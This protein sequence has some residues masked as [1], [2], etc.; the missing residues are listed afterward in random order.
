MTSN[1][2]WDKAAIGSK[3]ISGQ[4]DMSN[5]TVKQQCQNIP[6]VGLIPPTCPILRYKVTL[7]VGRIHLA[8]EIP[9]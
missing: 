7:A 1:C 6:P 3:H 2:A 8:A 4:T 9:D 5:S